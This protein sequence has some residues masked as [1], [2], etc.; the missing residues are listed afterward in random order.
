MQG[1]GTAMVTHHIQVSGSKP[2]ADA[3]FPEENLVRSGRYMN[4]LLPPPALRVPHSQSA[5]QPRE[6]HFSRSFREFENMAHGTCSVSLAGN[7]W[8]QALVL[9]PSTVLGQHGPAL[10]ISSHED[11]LGSIL[12]YIIRHLAPLSRRPWTFRLQTFA[13]AVPPTWNAPPWFP[14]TNKSFP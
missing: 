6:R 8:T 12:Y 13:Q 2:W 10:S 4:A 7:T 1:K 9:G 11:L 3:K 14:S 5:A